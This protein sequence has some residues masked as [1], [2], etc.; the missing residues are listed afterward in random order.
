MNI[1]IKYINE[2]K[3]TSESDLK[4]VFWRLSKKIH[5]DITSIELNNDQFIKLKNDFDQ[6]KLL[7]A[8]PSIKVIKSRQMFC[9]EDCISIFLD[10]MASNFPIE[11]TIKNYIYNQRIE[12]LN[13][14]LNQLIP[15]EID[16]FYKFQEEMY[17]LKGESTISNHL[18]GSV[19]MYFYRYCDYIY[20]KN[21]NN[22]NYLIIGYNLIYEIFESKQMYNG[23]KFI[24]WLVEDIIGSD[25]LRKNVP[26]TAST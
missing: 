3:I 16:L 5:P 9:K 13:I 2:N 6:A 1:F 7:L 10:L 11:K 22:K 18:F 4:R 14:C 20:L 15:T 24:N 19:K 12:L 26:T 23:I 8:K 17:L 25:K 21:K